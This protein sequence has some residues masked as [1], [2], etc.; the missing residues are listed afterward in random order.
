MSECDIRGTN[1]VIDPRN[2]SLKMYKYTFPGRNVILVSILQVMVG[3]AKL[4]YLPPE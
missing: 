3:S 4:L 2:R 1:I